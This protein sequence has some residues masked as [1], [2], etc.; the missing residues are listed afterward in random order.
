MFS[1]KYY[2]IHT[3]IAYGTYLYRVIVKNSF[4]SPILKYEL[5]II[6]LFITINNSIKIL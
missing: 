2:R 1:L 4:R 5:S 3:F 6:Q